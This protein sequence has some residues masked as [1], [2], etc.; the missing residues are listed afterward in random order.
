MLDII[1]AIFGLIGGAFIIV[2]VLSLIEG[3]FNDFKYCIMFVIIC[4]IAPIFCIYKS[5]TYEFKL[6]KEEK[7]ITNKIEVKNKGVDNII[8]K[9]IFKKP[10][11]INV[12]TY[13]TGIM[14]LQKDYQEYKVIEKYNEK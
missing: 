4:I 2:L 10:M 14:T 1:A 11:L 13:S 12:K 7:I 6:I 3:D 8:N 9:V 5:S